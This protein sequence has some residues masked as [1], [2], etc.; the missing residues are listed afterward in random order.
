M[1][2][3]WQGEQ[4]Q[5]LGVPGGA[6]DVE[7]GD[8][9]E[10]LVAVV[11]GVE[12]PLPGVVIQHG[13]VGILVVEGHVRVLIAGR[14]GEVGEVDL[15][16]GQVGVGHIEHPA[17]HEGLAGTALGVA[18]VPRAHDL[19]GVRVQPADHNVARILIGG[20]HG[21]EPALVHH[22]VHVR[23]ATPGVGEGVVVAGP[24]EAPLHQ[25]GAGAEVVLD[26][27]I[28]L[29]LVVE[30]GAI[31]HHVAGASPRL[32]QQVLDKV[33]ALDEVS[34][35]AELQDAPALVIAIHVPDLRESCWSLPGHRR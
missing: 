19:Q 1:A 15:G 16:P 14:V 18:G 32:G 4:R 7:E 3:V 20:V 26:H 30:Q 29:V 21:P 23:E 12:G 28:A 25:D 27:H 10:H 17:D 2:L 9:V 34:Q 33:L 6:D 13:D 31:V 11:P 5:P 35:S 8:V 22:E 24:G